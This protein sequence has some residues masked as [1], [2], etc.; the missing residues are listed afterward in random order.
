MFFSICI[1]GV[2]ICSFTWKKD[3]IA[4]VYLFVDEATHLLKNKPSIGYKSLIPDA[5]TY[6]Q[7]RYKKNM[8]ATLYY[9]KMNASGT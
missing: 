8:L 6:L 9:M 1:G 4:E 2:R 5:E 7:R 3:Y